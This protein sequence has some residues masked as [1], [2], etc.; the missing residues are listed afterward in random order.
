MSLE[1]TIRVETANNSDDPPSDGIQGD[2]PDQQERQHHQG[3]A[4]LPVA[5]NPRDHHFDT[6]DQQCTGEEHPAG[7]G[8]AKPATEPSPIA[9]ESGHA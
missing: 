2:D 9:S 7:P 5:V 3:C 6:A 8:K 1:P 4:A